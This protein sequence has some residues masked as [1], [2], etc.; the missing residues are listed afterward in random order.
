MP[1]RVGLEQRVAAEDRAPPVGVEEE[2]D[3]PA[4]RSSATCARVSVVPEP[5]GCS[6]TRSS[7]K[8][9]A[10]R[11][12]A[13]IDQDVDRE[14]HRPA[15]V[16][17]AAEEAG[18]R[19]A[20]L[21]VDAR[22]RSSPQ[23]EDERLGQVPP[24]QRPQPVRGQELRLVEHRRED[25]LAAAR[26]RPWTAAAA[27]RRRARGSA[28]R[29]P[30]ASGRFATNQSV[31]LGEARA[32]APGSRRPASSSR[33]AAAAR[34][35]SARASAAARPS[36]C[37]QH[38]VEE[39]VCSSHRPLLVRRASAMQGEVL[40]ELRGDV[41]VRRV[42]ARRARGRSPAG[43]GSTSPSS[44]VPSLCSSTPGD[45]AA[46]ARAVERADVVQAEEAALEDVVALG[47]PCG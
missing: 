28:R 16:G 24:R 15:P 17:V 30:R 12:S 37:G 39:A 41:L 36:G 4:A 10:N 40:E 47:C 5:V 18:R 1:V 6:T 27:R 13:S 29:P 33:T 14:P 11:R 7:P 2:R 22:R 35:S 8:K 3:Q 43:P 34:P 25:P 23:V 21:V 42:V 46:A 20:R 9:A 26:G 32:A 38:V 44:A 19:L 31:A 45:R